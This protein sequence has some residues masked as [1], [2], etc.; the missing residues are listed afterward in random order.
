[1]ISLPAIE[2]VLLP[3]Y[4]KKQDEG[5]CLAVTAS[6]KQDPPEIILFATKKIDRDTANKHIQKSGMSP[7]HNIRKII[8]VAEIPLLGTGK[9]DYQSLN[10]PTK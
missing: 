8:E 3:Y 10:I 2:T 1:M 7:L 5:P 6:D 9:I 4:T